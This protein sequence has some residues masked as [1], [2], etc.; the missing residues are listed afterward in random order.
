MQLV[1][2]VWRHQRGNQNP[3][4]AEEQPTQWPEE[5]VQKD[6]Q[7]STKQ[8][9][10]TKYRVTRTPLKIGGEFICSERVSSSCSN[11]GT[12]RVNLV[13]KPVINHERGKDLGVITTSGTYQIYLYLVTWLMLVKFVHHIHCILFQKVKVT[14]INSVHLTRVSSAKNSPATLLFQ[15]VWK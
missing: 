10:K 11:S 3:Y 5:K 4:I 15:Q 2:I 9:Y 6:K 1:R 14:G 8:T 13:T 12:R 7:R